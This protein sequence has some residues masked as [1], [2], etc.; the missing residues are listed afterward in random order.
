MLP[1]L[2]VAAFGGLVY[3]LYRRGIFGRISPR[4]A[5]I[6]VEVTQDNTKVTRSNASGSTSTSTGTS[7]KTVWVAESF[8]LVKG[9]IGPNIKLLQSVCKIGVDGK[10]GNDTETAIKKKGYSLPLS[11]KSWD[12]ICFGFDTKNDGIPDWANTFFQKNK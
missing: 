2:I 11:R 3:L 12:M 9:M 7:T 5:P 6:E 8:P 4:F 1:V 10:L